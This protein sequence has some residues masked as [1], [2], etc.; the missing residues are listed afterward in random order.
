MPQTLLLQIGIDQKWFLTLLVTSDQVDPTEPDEKQFSA[1]IGMPL[2]LT[3]CL[4]HL[5]LHFFGFEKKT[6]FKRVGGDDCFFVGVI[7]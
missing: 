3:W 4:I 6:L 5:S 2:W 7:L 1:I